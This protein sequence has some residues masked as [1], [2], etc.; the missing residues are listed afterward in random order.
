MAIQ[1]ERMSVSVC[2]WLGGRGGWARGD[3]GEEVGRKLFLPCAWIHKSRSPNFGE[4]SLKGITRGNLGK[5]TSHSE[6]AL[7]LG[8][9]ATKCKVLAVVIKKLSSQ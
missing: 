9:T 7:L 8:V 4:Y 5:S 3:R 6:A 2:V 1:T